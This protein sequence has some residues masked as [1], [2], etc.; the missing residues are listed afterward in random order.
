MSMDVRV[1]KVGGRRDGKL[2]LWWIKSGSGAR[3]IRHLTKRKC[4][5]CRCGE[6]LLSRLVLVVKK[7]TGLLCS[8]AAGTSR[9]LG[10]GLQH[11]EDEE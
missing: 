3:N 10:A 2:V 4:L 5:W 8:G 7:A 11:G 1:A 6:E 9:F